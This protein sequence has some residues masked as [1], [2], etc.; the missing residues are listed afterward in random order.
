MSNCE[1][2]LLFDMSYSKLQKQVSQKKKV[3]TFLSKVS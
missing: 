1:Y 2:L 3:K